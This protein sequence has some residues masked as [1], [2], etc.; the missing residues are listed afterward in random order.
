MEGDLRYGPARSGSEQAIQLRHGRFAA[1]GEAVLF[2]PEIAGHYELLYSGKDYAAEAKAIE[3][4][5]FDARRH[6]LLDVGCAVGLHVGELGKLGFEATGM[7]VDPALIA[8]A[9]TRLPTS[10]FVVGDVAAFDLGRTF[11]VITC[12]YGSIAYVR[13]K[14]RLLS[15]FECLVRHLSP[16]G[17]LIVEPWFSPSTYRAGEVTARAVQSA[18]VAIARCQAR[19]IDSVDERIAIQDIRYL[20]G[21]SGNQ[22]GLSIVSER[23]EIGLFDEKDYRDCFRAL[24]LTAET[25]PWRGAHGIYVIRLSR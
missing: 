20:I 3:E 16:G 6:T 11:D 24:G 7:D 1:L 9:R 12:L 2:H 25:P 17:V 23:H 21:I 4:I 22:D 5:A 15:S 10:T 19:L 8:R 13:T 18:Q 14:E